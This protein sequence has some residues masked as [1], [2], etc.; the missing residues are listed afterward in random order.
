MSSSGHPRSVGLF[1]DLRSLN[2]INKHAPVV[3]SSRVTMLAGDLAGVIAVIPPN[4]VAEITHFSV[5]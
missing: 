3:L 1:R 4:L 5:Q 2:R